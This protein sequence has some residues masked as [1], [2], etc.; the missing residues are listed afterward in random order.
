MS[1]AVSHCSP[2]PWRL[3]YTCCYIRELI[4][5]DLRVTCYQPQTST[6]RLAFR[7]Q[8]SDDVSRGVAEPRQGPGG[9][10]RD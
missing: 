5:G 8:V 2:G 6:S 4:A 1:P 9:S 10:S 3:C 7:R